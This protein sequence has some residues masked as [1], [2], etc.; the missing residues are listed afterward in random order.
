[1]TYR[2]RTTVSLVD[3]QGAASLVTEAQIDDVLEALCEAHLLT[4]G[5]CDDVD[6]VEVDGGYHLRIMNHIGRG[7]WVV[8]A[9][10]LTAQV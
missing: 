10:R 5:N 4:G 6:Y 3:D 9:T 7:W 1:M 2:N 8:F